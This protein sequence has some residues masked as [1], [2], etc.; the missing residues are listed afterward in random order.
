VEAFEPLL[1][2]TDQVKLGIEMKLF[3]KTGAVKL[4]S[5]VVEVSNFIRKGNP[6]VPIALKV[7]VD[8]LDAG[9]YKLEMTVLDSA[10]HSVKKTTS[11]NVE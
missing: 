4:D 2:T 1:A 10:N 3:D 7:P 6:T 11:F 8:K 5:G 9:S